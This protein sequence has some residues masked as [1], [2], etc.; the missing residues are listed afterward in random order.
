MCAHGQ[1]LLCIRAQLLRQRLALSVLHNAL[2]SVRKGQRVNHPSTNASALGCHLRSSPAGAPEL[3][4]Q[5]AAPDIRSCHTHDFPQLR[6]WQAIWTGASTGTAPR[7]PPK[8]LR[9]T[10]KGGEAQNIRLRGRYKWQYGDAH[11]S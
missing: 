9:G 3:C 2:S 10:Y 1:A 11:G 7:T 8:A 4:K 5:E 6:Q